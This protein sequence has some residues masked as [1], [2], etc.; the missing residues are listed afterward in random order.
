M[1]VTWMRPR[2][3]RAKGYRNMNVQ[4]TRISRRISCSWC[5]QLMKLDLENLSRIQWKSTKRN[6]RRRRK[7]RRD[8]KRSNLSGFQ[9][10]RP[11][12][13]EFNLQKVAVPFCDIPLSPSSSSVASGDG[14]LSGSG[15]DGKEVRKNCCL[16]ETKLMLRLGNPTFSRWKK[17]VWIPTCRHEWGEFF[18]R[19]PSNEP[20]CNGYRQ[21]G[22]QH[23]DGKGS[24]ACDR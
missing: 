15:G 9:L 18:N 1:E 21:P 24:R 23:Y 6:D 19:W 17:I 16:K 8:K 3:N 13:S 11:R 12:R 20:E 10:D 22:W 7:P 2:R 4:S 5:R 14:S